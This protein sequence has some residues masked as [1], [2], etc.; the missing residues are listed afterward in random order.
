MP[1]L[2]HDIRLGF[3]QISKDYSKD[4]KGQSHQ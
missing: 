1:V 4:S 2:D 3:G